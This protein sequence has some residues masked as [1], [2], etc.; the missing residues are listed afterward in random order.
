VLYADLFFQLAQISGTRGAARL[1]AMRRGLLLTTLRYG[2]VTYVVNARRERK[3][4]NRLQ[5][6]IGCEDEM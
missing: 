1:L 2:T 4:S 3:G 6:S 5:N